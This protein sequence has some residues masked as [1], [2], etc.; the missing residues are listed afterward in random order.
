MRHAATLDL[1]QFEDAELY[2][3][4]ERARRQTVGRIGLFT[5]LLATVQD[6]ITLITL[7]RGAGASTSP[8]CSSCW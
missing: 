7:G 3:K 5:L 1:E 6:A 2:D 8:G 4:L